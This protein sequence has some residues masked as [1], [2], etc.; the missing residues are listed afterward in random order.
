ML[1]LHL[2]VLFAADS[3]AV[4]LRYDVPVEEDGGTRAQCPE[5]FLDDF[6]G[7]TGSF[8]LQI[9][10]GLGIAEDM[11]GATFTVEKEITTRSEHRKMRK[12]FDFP[13]DD[14]KIH[15]DSDPVGQRACDRT[16]YFKPDYVPVEVAGQDFQDEI[17]HSS[18]LPLKFASELKATRTADSGAKKEEVGHSVWQRWQRLLTTPEY[19]SK[20]RKLTSRR[21]A[22]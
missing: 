11:G 22:G 8:F 7:G 1:H 9:V 20:I 17:A 10:N 16:L 6:M 13:E 5:I 18:V 4:H 15:V 2:V 19:A 21:A 3:A 12:I 14:I